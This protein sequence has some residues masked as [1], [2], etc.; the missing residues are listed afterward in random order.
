MS[1]AARNILT[2]NHD[3]A[4]DFF[5]K[6]EQYHGFELPEYFTFDQVLKNV[7][8]KIGVTP[9]EECVQEN[10]SPE[11]L[12]DVNLDI[13]LNKD[14]RYAV[15]P[16]IL[17][18]PFLYYF[19]V[20]EV[21]C[22]SNWQVIK[23][24]FE[25]FNV[26]HITS[27]AIPV[28]PNEKEPFHKATTIN[29]WWNSMEQRSIELSLEYRYMFVT[30]ITNCYGSIN[31]QTFDWA[32]SLKGTSLETEDES[33]IAKN[34]QNYLRAFQQGRN[35]G[36]PQGSVIFDLIA[37]IVLGYSDLLL[38]EAL[39]A[40]VK[41][42]KE[43][44]KTFPPYE[45]IRYRDDYRIFCS[46]RDALEDISY[47][48]QK[49]LERL[50]F[51]MNSQKTKISDSI[52]TDAVKSDK[53]AYIYNTPIFNKK[54]VDFDSFEK[55]LLYILMLSRQYPDSGSVR[56]ML[57]DIDKRIE[58][59]L[60]SLDEKNASKAED[61]ESVDL[62]DEAKPA[63]AEGVFSELKTYHRSK[64]IPGGSIRALSAVCTQIALENVGCAHYALRVISRMIDSLDDMD[65]K[66]SII[67][68]VYQK[69]CN[70][71]NSYYNQ[72]W[73][74][75]MTYT[76]DKK[77]GT[78]PYT[79]RLCQLVAGKTVEPL[80]NNDWLK[81]E[82]TTNIPYESIVDGEILKKVTPVITFRETR[83]YNEIEY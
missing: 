37:E 61:W 53:L 7:R 43:K 23:D 38:H 64:Y 11:E 76:Q 74:Q 52:V 58:D 65:E 69:L 27:C 17:A 45:I 71:P 5:M 79:L 51:R 50:N 67:D 46:N 59:Y 15:R 47:I 39:Q 28:I 19:L 33:T 18:N 80:W 35:I 68:L 12:S 20:R 60:K 4:M 73:L 83:R 77:Q 57:S 72:L 36:I 44:G 41:E 62:G 55:H 8:E 34:I 66:R 82:L 9:Y 21:C 31:P 6:S 3:E 42:Y 63:K 81:A 48:L 56:T 13:L 54:G 10:I 40:K 30:D 29:N 49:V 24:L 16:I 14:G 32:F 2:L 70:Q 25:K 75:N 1:K 22:E 78:S 26:P